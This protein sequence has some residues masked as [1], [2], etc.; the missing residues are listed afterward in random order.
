MIHAHRVLLAAAV[1]AACATGAAAGALRGPPRTA[2]AA[3]PSSRR[4]TYVEP[5]SGLRPTH[6]K[7]QVSGAGSAVV[8]G[9]YQK[10]ESSLYTGSSTVGSLMWRQMNPAGGYTD[11]CILHQEAAWWIGHH[12]DATADYYKTS[13]DMTILEWSRARRRFASVASVS[14]DPYTHLQVASIRL[15]LMALWMRARACGK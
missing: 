11:L 6:E 5:V 15:I 7:L 9:V 13:G 1:L 12:L 10:V 8:N 2:R 4:E 3:T 14:Q